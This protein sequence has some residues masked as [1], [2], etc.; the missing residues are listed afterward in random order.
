MHK[1]WYTIKQ[2]IL[3]YSYLMPYKYVKI[4]CIKSRYLIACLL[5]SWVEGSPT[6]LKTGVQSL[7]ESY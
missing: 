1:G 2:N 7:V 5:A 6:A 4:M 3:T